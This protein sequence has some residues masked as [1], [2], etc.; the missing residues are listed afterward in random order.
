MRALKISGLRLAS[1]KNYSYQM[2]LGWALSKRTR[3]I[4][5]E[6]SGSF[7]TRDF[8]E[9]FM[10]WS[11][12]ATQSDCIHLLTYHLLETS[13]SVQSSTTLR[14]QRGARRRRN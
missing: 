6:Q 5:E 10:Q 14:R 8:N 9:K 12:Q 4:I 2:P 7:A 3:E 1:L 13:S 11:N